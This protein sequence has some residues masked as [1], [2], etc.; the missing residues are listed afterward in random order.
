MKSEKCDFAIKF[1]FG[2]HVKGKNDVYYN[3]FYPIFKVK[4]PVLYKK[5]VGFNL[6][7][8]YGSGLGSIL[9]LRKHQSL[10]AETYTQAV[11][12]K[13]ALTQAITTFVTL[14]CHNKSAFSL[15]PSAML[16]SPTHLD[17]HPPTFLWGFPWCV[18]YYTFFY[19]QRELANQKRGSKRGLLSSDWLTLACCYQSSR[20]EV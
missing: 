6:F 7:F 8:D 9:T 20:E 14:W 2:S 12:R 19:L 10:R 18:L 13:W 1:H 17:P 15:Q 11:L 5:K 4:G 16:P 3:Y